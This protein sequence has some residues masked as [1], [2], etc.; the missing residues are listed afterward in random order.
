MTRLKWF[1]SVRTLFVGALAI[2]LLGCQSE[3]PCTFEGEGL[4]APS[5]GCLVL[6]QGQ[7]LL[8]EIPGGTYGPPGGSTDAG[9]SAQCAAERETYEETGV[10][11]KAGELA[12]EFDNGF[13]LFWCE[14]MSGREITIERPLEIM[15]A[16][17][18]TPERFMQLRWRYPQQGLVVNELLKAKEL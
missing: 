18:Y 10:I 14:S 16:D 4:H 2:C 6:N 1:T 11:A 17:W 7:I 15:S 8:V 13:H 3:P 12:M 5:A 9:E